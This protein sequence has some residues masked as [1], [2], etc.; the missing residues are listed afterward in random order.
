MFQKRIIAIHAVDQ[1]TLQPKHLNRYFTI[2]K[3]IGYK[4]LPLDEI[5]SSKYKGKFISLTVDDA[6]KST[7][8][9]LLPIL[10]TYNI[11]A[12]LFVPPSL[13]GLK[14]NDKK[15]LAQYCYS[16][17]D[18]MTI[19]DLKIWK[20][21]GHEIAFHTDEHID[22]YEANEDVIISDF[23][24]GMEKMSILGYKIK[25]FAYPKGFLPKNRFEFEKLLQEYSIQ[26]AFTITWGKLNTENPYYINRLCLGDKEPLFWS[27]LKTIGI[28]DWYYLKQKIKY[29]ERVR[30]N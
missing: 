10:N 4:F 2:L 23:K 20:N 19:E 17:Q 21:N 7:I 12:T 22:L 9:N 25:Y 30:H 5:F 27:I 15:L 6:Y 28:V 18:M 26:K 16:D 24:S 13:L 11:K 29:Y 3:S 14:A 1:N 8:T